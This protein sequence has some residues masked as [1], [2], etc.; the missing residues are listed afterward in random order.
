M[1]RQSIAKRLKMRSAS[2]VLNLLGSVAKEALTPMP[3]EDSLANGY[4]CDRALRLPTISAIAPRALTS[5]WR[6]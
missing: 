2:S 5:R 6:G 3:N 4:V 1:T